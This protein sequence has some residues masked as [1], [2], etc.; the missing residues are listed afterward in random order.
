[1]SGRRAVIAGG[2][3]VLVL[4]VLGYRAWDR[5]ALGGTTGPAYA[6]WEEW[7]GHEVDGNR[8]PFAQPFLRRART[9]RRP[10]GLR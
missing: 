9:I 1:M 5:R 6:A 10:G 2:A 4:T 8:R 7:R 3:G